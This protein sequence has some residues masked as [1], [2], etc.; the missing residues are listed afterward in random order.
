MPSEKETAVSLLKQRGVEKPTDGMV[1]NLTD[2]IN[3]SP[4][5]VNN[6][7]V[8]EVIAKHAKENFKKEEAKKEK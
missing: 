6:G 7:Q 4:G 2:K 3:Q 5:F 8:D 1:R